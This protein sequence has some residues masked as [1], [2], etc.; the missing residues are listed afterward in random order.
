VTVAR[1]LL[2]RLAL[3]AVLILLVPSITFFLEAITPGNVASLLLGTNATRQEVQELSARLGL[4]QPLYEQY[5]HWLTQLLTGN[6][7]TSYLNG[8]RVSAIIGQRLPV[9]LS[10]LGG[11]LILAS[12]LGVGL[13]VVSAT[14]GRA[15]ARTVDVGSIIGIAAPSFWIAI[16]LVLIFAV[17][18]RALPAI[19]YV[20]IN[21]SPLQWLRSLILPWIALGLG[22]MTFIAKQTRDQMLSV[23]NRDFIRTLRANGVSERSIIFRHALRNAGIPVVTMIGLSFVGAL[24]GSVF[25]EQVFVLPGL[26]SALVLAATTHDLPVI[27]GISVVFTVM[28]VVVSLVADLLYAALDPR[29]RTAR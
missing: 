27:E 12:I 2:R 5:W 11:S 4:S 15:V 8:E 29:I 19:G 26:G 1:L 25:V 6:L 13:G 23:L 16:G 9:S 7:G 28:V 22:L 3:S 18:L 24:S 21:V 14:R 10:I 20:A 17:T